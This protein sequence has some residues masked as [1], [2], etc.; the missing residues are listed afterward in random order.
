[1][2]DQVYCIISKKPF[3]KTIKIKFKKICNFNCNTN[4]NSI[5]LITLIKR[6]S[7]KLLDTN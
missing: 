4:I 6:Q 2:K 1:M 5:I 3:A 7:N